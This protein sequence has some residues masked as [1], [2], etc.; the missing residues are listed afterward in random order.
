MSGSSNV[1]QVNEPVADLEFAVQN[2]EDY[3]DLRQAW[4]ALPRV[5]KLVNAATCPE[6]LSSRGQSIRLVLKGEESAGAL[7]V[8][9]VTMEPGA[10]AAPNHNQPKEDEFWFCVKGTFDW[11]VRD[12]TERVGPGAFAYVPR[13]VNHAFQQVGDEPAVMFTVNTPA[14][15][16]RGFVGLNRLAAENAGLDVL[17]K[18]LADHDFVF[19]KPFGTE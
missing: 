10:A 1:P 3:Q 12:K 17:G 19:E 5:P 4:T 2:N 13:G 11:T 6:I 7:M 18:H 14:G 8:A 9:Y 15:H 16:E